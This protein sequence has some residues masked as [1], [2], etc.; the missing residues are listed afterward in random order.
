MNSIKEYL[1]LSEMLQTVIDDAFFKNDDYQTSFRPSL[2]F[3]HIHHNQLLGRMRKLLTH[4]SKH[5][6]I[7]LPRAK[8]RIHLFLSTVCKI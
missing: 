7:L 4:A 6:P 8:K 2:H 3:K 1:Q 5:H